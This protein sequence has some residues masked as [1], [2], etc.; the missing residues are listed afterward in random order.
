MELLKSPTTPKHLRHPAVYLSGSNTEWR[1]SLHGMLI[2]IEGMLLVPDYSNPT[3]EYDYSRNADVITFWF[4]DMFAPA[5]A[6]LEYHLEHRSARIVIG[7]NIDEEIRRRIATL[8][9]K[10]TI[11]TSLDEVARAIVV[12]LTTLPNTKDWQN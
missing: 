3:W 6:E 4:D 11:Q 8:R 9:P 10:L 7:G 1:K 12:T 5:A 2:G